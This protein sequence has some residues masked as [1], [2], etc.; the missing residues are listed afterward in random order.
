M[1]G[2]I[3]VSVCH[4]S[5]VQLAELKV[6]E[7]AITWTNKRTLFSGMY[8]IIRIRDLWRRYQNELSDW[9]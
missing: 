1:G 6:Q 7:S 9:N 8:I 2:L 4:K 3:F 5:A